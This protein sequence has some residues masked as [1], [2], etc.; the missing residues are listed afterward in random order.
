MIAV[1]AMTRFTV[2]APIASLR[3]ETLI[4][5]L[6]EVDFLRRAAKVFDTR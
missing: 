6:E 5:E 4:A 1:C 2:C 3:P